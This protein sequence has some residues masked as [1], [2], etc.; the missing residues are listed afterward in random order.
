MLPSAR[1]AGSEM[2]ISPITTM[3]IS[4]AAITAGTAIDCCSE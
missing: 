2:S 4:P 1:I 3:T